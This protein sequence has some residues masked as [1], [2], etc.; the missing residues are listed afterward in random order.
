[1]TKRHIMPA[2][3]SPRR[4]SE[5][6]NIQLLVDTIPSLIHTAMPNGCLDYFDQPWLE[7]LEV[8]LDEVAGWKWKAFIHPRTLRESG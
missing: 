5:P 1:M 3:A 6:L 7:Y 8:A 2:M 4:E